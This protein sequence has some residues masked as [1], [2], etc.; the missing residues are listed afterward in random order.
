VSA[1]P[2][3][4]QCLDDNA[5]AELVEGRLEGDALASAE[6]HLAECATC[7]GLV[8]R[9]AETAL[10]S[11]VAV[12][13]AVTQ[14]SD[15]SDGSDGSDPRATEVSHLTRGERVGR[16]QVIELVGAGAMGTVYSAHD[17]S[18]DRTVALK[19]LHARAIDL[20][21]ET[22]L[23]REAKAMARLSHP[24]VISVFDAGR[25]GERLFIAMEF[26]DG[27][28]LREWLG[29]APRGWREIVAV[30]L[31]A[32]RGLAQAHSAGIVHRDF[33][34]D[35]VLVG[36]DGRV[37]VTDFGLA[38]AARSDEGRTS[39]PSA[40]AESEAPN[41]DAN[42]TRTGALVGT[43]AYMAPEQLAGR[44]AD[45]RSDVYSFSL[46]LYEALY[47]ER[48]FQGETLA[49]LSAA[50]NAGDVRPAP[51]GSVIA[52]RLRRAL[53]V[54]LR[55][56]PEERYAS[57]VAVL[58]ALERATR[59]S[60]R[61]VVIGA[62]VLASVVVTGFALGAWSRSGAKGGAA[63]ASASASIASVGGVGALGAACTTHR[64]CVE[65]HG[66]LPYRCR[67][68]DK[69]CV[70]IGSE[71]CV[72]KFEPSDLAS[73]DTLWL[74]AMFPTKGPAAASHGS[75][76]AEGTDL[77]RA[78]IAGATRGLEGSN[79]SLRVRRIALV[80]CDDSE[81]PM[82]AAKHLVDD[83]GVPAI[84]GFGTGQELVEVAGA[85]LV[86]RRVLAVA[87]LTSAPL[88]TRL[89]QPPDLPRMVW[90]TT[91][92]VDDF[93][94][95]TAHVIPDVIEPRQSRGR[96]TRVALARVDNAASLSFAEAMYETLRFNGKSALENGR[97]YTENIVSAAATEVEIASAAERVAA[98]APSVVVVRVA[99]E[100]SFVEAVES[101][102][103][104]DAPR[105]TYVFTGGTLAPFARYLGTNVDRRR[106]LFGLQ[107]LS[108]SNVN[109]RFVM[110]YNETHKDHVSLTFNPS[111]SYDAFYLL[112]LAAFSLGAEADVTGPLLGR[113]FERMVPP[114]RLIEVGP[115]HVF[116]ALT[117]VAA[118]GRIDLEGATSALD[119]D[120]ATG[121]APSDF[122]LL[123]SNVDS[124][125]RATGEDVESGIVFRAKT[126]R[127]EGAL[128]CP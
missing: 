98:N 115:T 10:E 103:R 27:G 11:G 39:E 44:P 12:G 52:S 112:S 56:R 18:L 36:K 65:S 28:T 113:A 117:V 126:Q 63:V 77:A 58:D 124:D 116:D 9:A 40:H 54:G 67:A 111:S 25:H 73:E 26:V 51:A 34:P 81:D 106:R 66:G 38:R 23:L 60:N 50:K 71:D 89:P 35:N 6:A 90:R 76:N 96:T 86:G 53:L 41:V 91:S 120:L 47:G 31:R 19:L 75:M 22:R 74:G 42:L 8:A 104:A 43:P 32:G 109:A 3:D 5:L 102:W 4:R 78:E 20:E 88:V 7:T 114:G 17:P 108:S 1:E 83:V 101:R 70:A 68:S 79:A 24:E 49:A 15:G 105:P 55:V 85:L 87:S 84:I 125:G 2:V 110:R 100:A 57:M 82:R 99:N 119:F 45:V 59:G 16:Y 62:S 127:I 61:A 21:L 107:S 37:R 94:H 93:A 33:K 92:S 80:V 72:P 14:R 30:Y 29:E 64:A 95:A 128:R 97:L 121:E 46:A 122:A 13:L 48:P 69:T 123:C 118:G